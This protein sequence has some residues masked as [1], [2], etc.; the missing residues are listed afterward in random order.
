MRLNLR[1]ES[2]GKSWLDIQVSLYC[3]DGRAEGR[4]AVIEN[5]AERARRNRISLLMAI[6]N[7]SERERVWQALGLAV[8]FFVSEKYHPVHDKPM[9]MTPGILEGLIPVSKDSEVSEHNE[10]VRDTLQ[11]RS[12]EIA[13][14][15]TE[16]ADCPTIVDGLALIYSFTR[17]FRS[18][19]TK[20]FDEV[21]VRAKALG[22]Q[23][24][25]VSVYYM[26]DE[27]LRSLD[28]YKKRGLDLKHRIKT[29]SVFFKDLES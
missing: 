11:K 1:C 7:L 17:H 18:R 5:M 6:R 26:T 25:P 14:I 3:P 15:R 13:K 9:L 23:E 19:Q 2:T 27:E 24:R 8:W 10:A 4:S 20:D 22:L 21:L 29:K 12:G 16:L 28:A